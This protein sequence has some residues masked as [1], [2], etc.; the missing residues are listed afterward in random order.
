MESIG[1]Q[2]E[3]MSDAVGFEMESHAFALL[4]KTDDEAANA[5]AGALR[6]R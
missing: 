5:A 4:Q 6:H 2:S 1:S 3:G